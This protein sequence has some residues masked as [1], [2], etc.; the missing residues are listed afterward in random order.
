MSARGLATAGLVALLFGLGSLYVHEEMPLFALVN[1]GLAVLALAAAGVLGWRRGAGGGLPP[2]ARRIRLL[3]A[4]SVVLAIGI[5]ASAVHLLD[6]PSLV[7]DWTL[8]GRYTL[9]PATREA[10]ASLHEPVVATLFHDRFDNR[11]RGTRLLL[12]TLAAAGPVTVRDRLLD[13]A[14]DEAR[15]YGVG[16]SNTVVLSAGSRWELLERPTEGT[17]FEALERLAEPR[18]AVIYVA[19]GEGEGRFD[20]SEPSGFSGLAA[21]LET[22]GY[23]LRALM[24]PA[25]ERIPDDAAAVLLV[26]PQRP[27]R[28]ESLAAL[29]AYLERGGHVV[30]L[31]E[32]G[33][34]TG[35][36]KLLGRW[37]FALPDDVVVDPASGPIEGDPPG[38][39]PIVFE[40]SDHPVV[41]G[42]G[43]NR[44]LFFR[45]ARPVEPVHKPRPDDELRGLAF[46]SRRSWLA[47]NVDEIQHGLP[48][49]RPPDAKE[50][51]QPLVAFGRYERDGHEAR[52]VVFGDSDFASNRYLRTLY[53]LDVAVNAVHWAAGRDPA[54]TLR[55][56]I[57]TPNQFPLTP[58]QSLRMLYGVGLAVPELC[59]VA[60]AWTW[61]R[62]R[63]A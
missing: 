12:D 44:T 21:A 32:P 9:A 28:A 16:S 52:I 55:P 34:D 25:T 40:F 1:L 46:S 5:S 18:R 19:T 22:E 36:E 62:R 27:L 8:D 39:N 3:G 30:A 29:D 41:R 54:I 13:Q 2:A 4:A 57:L 17:L 31:L 42:L 61:A 14:D 15:R 43:P 60:A 37:G 10:L 56:K 49:K 53:N 7:W 50:D 35:L 24:M 26:A 45:R 38:V 63:S 59:L 51:Y 33:S 11:A 20:R 48:P 47:P 6:R 58:Q 23:R